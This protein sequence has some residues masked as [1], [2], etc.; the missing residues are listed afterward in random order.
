MQQQGYRISSV[1]ALIRFSAMTTIN[2]IMAHVISNCKNN[3]WVIGTF[4]FM[5]C[6]VMSKRS[7]R[8][9]N[10]YFYPGEWGNGLMLIYTLRC[11]GTYV[12]CSFVSQCRLKVFTG[13]GN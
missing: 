2:I 4:F 8:Y 6:K 11:W 7:S 5:F 9:E 1:S 10:S 3:M 12:V 13:F